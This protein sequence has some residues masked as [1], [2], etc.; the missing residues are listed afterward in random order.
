[1]GLDGAVVE[2][3]AESLELPTDV[4]LTGGEVDILPAQTQ[5]LTAAQ[6]VVLGAESPEF[7]AVVATKKVAQPD[8]SSSELT[9]PIR[10]AAVL[11]TPGVAVPGQELGQQFA[12]QRP[13]PPLDLPGGGQFIVSTACK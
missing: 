3:A 6:S 13:V 1:M 8:G 7:K 11:V 9:P 10:N 4:D 2:A 5:H 12:A